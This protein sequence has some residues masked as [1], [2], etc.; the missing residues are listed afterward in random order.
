MNQDRDLQTIWED[1]EDDVDL[2]QVDPAAL[3]RPNNP[4]AAESSSPPPPNQHPNLPSVEDE[5]GESSNQPET[6]HTDQ[7]LDDNVSLSDSDALGPD[8]DPE[9]NHEYWADWVRNHAQPHR[10]REEGDL[11]SE[12]EAPPDDDDDDDV[13]SIATSTSSW[14][15]DSRLSDEIV[16][17]P[18]LRLPSPPKNYDVEATETSRYVARLWIGHASMN[19]DANYHYVHFHHSFHADLL[20]EFRKDSRLPHDDIYVPPHLQPVNPE[21]EDDVV[22]DQHAAFGI[23]KAT[24]KVKEPAWRDLGLEELMSRGP[25]GANANQGP[26]ANNS[27][28]GTSS[29]AGAAAAGG[30]AGQRNAAPR[31][32][33][34]H[35][36]PG[37]GYRGLPR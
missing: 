22:P 11:T 32:R 27:Q 16:S 13:P 2:L 10:G 37:S 19:K 28:P 24:Q 18:E 33:P 9:I 25:G 35:R 34:G 23:Q 21:D 3:E 26:W 15:L 4:V 6:D 20:D 31:R 7:I 30:A 29:G 12:I 14:E 5:Q 36:A 1:A 8:G 17:L